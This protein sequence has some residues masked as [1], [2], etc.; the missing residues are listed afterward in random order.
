[1]FFACVR[2][3]ARLSARGSR[4]LLELTAGRSAHNRPVPEAKTCTALAAALAV[5]LSADRARARNFVRLQCDDD[6]AHVCPD[7]HAL[8]TKVA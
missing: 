6:G 4:D 7:G 5:A 2:T 3:L 1:M 8:G